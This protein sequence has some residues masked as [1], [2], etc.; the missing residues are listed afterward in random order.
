MKFATGL[1]AVSASLLSTLAQAEEQQIYISSYAE[2][3]RLCE[4]QAADGTL[5]F[6]ESGRSDKTVSGCSVSIDR[7]VFD[8][9]F[10]YCA[11]SGIKEYN[12]DRFVQEHDYG[13]HCNFDLQNEN[14]VFEAVRGFGFSEGSTSSLFCNFTCFETEIS[15]VIEGSDLD[16]IKSEP[17]P[18]WE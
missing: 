12:D 18:L 4:L 10:E 9:Q 5:P 8:R 6:E 17:L 16:A 11:L 2:Q 3:D 7:K 13:S 14:V 15:E 1:F